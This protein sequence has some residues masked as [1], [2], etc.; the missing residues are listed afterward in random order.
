MKQSLWVLVLFA[1]GTGFSAQAA[2]SNWKDQGVIFLEHTLNA[3]MQPVPVSAVR[4]TGG[5]WAA[6]RRVT[7]DHAL[8]ILL[9]F[10]QE[11]GAIDNFIKAA[12][13][14]PG[15]HRG[16]PGSDAGV[17]MWM[18]AAAWAIGS[19]DTSAADKQKLQASMNLLI[20]DIAAAQ[21]ASGYLD[22]Y[23]AGDRAHL[24]FT[25]PLHSREDYC[26]AHLLQ[27]GI[28]YYRA[29][30]RRNLLDIG[31]KFA[32]DLVLNFGPASQPYVTGY[33]V[34][35]MALVELYRTTG[36]TKYLD[37]AR[38]LLG[39]GGRDRLHLKDADVRAT[40]SG[41]PFPSRT[42]FEG[43]VLRALNAAAGAT[44]YFAESGDPAYKRTIDLLWTDLTTRRMTITGGVGTRG[45][46]DTFESPYEF[47][48]GGAFAD[49]CASMANVLWSFRLLALTGDAR[50]GDVL[51]RALYNGVNAGMSLSGD[52][53]CYRP[54]TAAGEEK[55]RNAFFESDCC[56]PD[57]TSLLEALPGYFYSIGRDGLYVNL[58][59]NSELDW[60]LD[61][62]APLKVVQT[63]DYPWSGEIKLA[64]Y[65]AK[66]SQFTIRLR[67]PSWASTADVLINGNSVSGDDFK[68]G[69][70]I[71]LNRMWAP[72][73]V[74]TLNL[75]VQTVAIRANPLAAGLYG[76]VA[77][78]RGPLVY[79]YEQIDQGSNP[80]PDIFLKP[81]ATGTAD[82]RKEMLG[83]ITVLKVPGFVAAKP[84]V[85]DPLYEPW[86]AREDRGRKPINVTLIPYFAVGN[87]EPD[88]IDVWAPATSAPETL[89][90]GAAEP[91][92]VRQLGERR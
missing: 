57:I 51:E 22:T 72:G 13:T 43:N 39:G 82:F 92:S 47:P 69:E 75:P 26:L 16:R 25:D 74:I 60:H 38:Y 73:D 6:R 18:E 44:D 81:T 54:S 46:S 4:I 11:H 88:A 55:M 83:G 49:P 52:L 78:E 5:L 24:R 71:P 17:Y 64:V 2:T 67:W 37:F 23:F 86:V 21:D 90:I 77:W 41:R 20:A 84:L 91:A 62:G 80:L 53:L 7:V 48:T 76:R 68:R 87:R 35:E 10:L 19:P 12:A 9:E 70:Y 89:P 33:P 58:Y 65:P 42:E 31:I 79:A 56:P 85:G 34:L 1:A 45:N 50:F 29:T 8:P 36:E 66:A 61:D 14:K 27:A 40:F 3:R 15:A 30:G 63:T 59:N 28:A 32:D